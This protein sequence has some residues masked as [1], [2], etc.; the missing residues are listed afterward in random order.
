MQNNNKLK[1]FW[2]AFVMF[3]TCVLCVEIIF[4]YLSETPYERVSNFT[5]EFHSAQ[6]LAIKAIEKH[7][8]IQT[9]IG[10][11]LL[12]VVTSVAVFIWPS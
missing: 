1:Y 6:N 2:C 7:G 10:T 8:K 4:G 3:C 5:F 9:A 11:L 12:G